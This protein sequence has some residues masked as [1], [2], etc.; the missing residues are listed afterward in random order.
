MADAREAILDAA[1]ELFARQGFAATTI[2]D[3]AAAARVNSALLYYYFTDK[4]ALYQAVLERF[5]SV[6]L[7]GFKA[8]GEV[9]TPADGIRA[10]IRLVSSR[11]AE[12]PHMARFL[13]RELADHEGKHARPFVERIASGPFGKLTQLVRGAQSAGMARADLRPEFAAISTMAQIFY[14]AIAQP[15]VGPLLGERIT[16]DVW[17]QFA[18]H[19][20]TFA[21]S[22]LR[23]V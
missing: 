15:I 3:I 2:K 20:A 6:A 12:R 7:E 5:L 19:A 18:D 8:M 22:A 4:E 16:P 14:F 23:P 1:E 17:A 9:K 13:A 21:S 11:F 10:I